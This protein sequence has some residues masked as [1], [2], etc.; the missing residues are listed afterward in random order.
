MTLSGRLQVPVDFYAAG[1]DLPRKEKLFKFLGIFSSK[2]AMLFYA[3]NFHTFNK[4]ARR[5]LK[6]VTINVRK[7]FTKK[8]EQL[9]KKRFKYISG[10]L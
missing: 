9:R 4:Q 2:K 6:T 1:L 10:H 5:A 7:V 3:C 8:K